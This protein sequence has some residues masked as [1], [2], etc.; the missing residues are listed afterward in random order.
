MLPQISFNEE[1]VNWWFLVFALGCLV[2]SLWFTI[3]SRNL[4]NK[5]FVIPLTNPWPA[6]RSPLSS[7]LWLIELMCGV[8]LDE[9]CKEQKIQGAQTTTQN[10]NQKQQLKFLLAFLF[11]LHRS[12]RAIPADMYCGTRNVVTLYTHHT[13]CHCKPGF[14]KRFCEQGIN[15]SLHVTPL[16]QTSQ[17]FIFNFYSEARAPEFNC[18]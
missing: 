8:L 15:L 6:I 7:P 9:R 16:Q 12:K 14:Q 13:E 11:L 5:I 4:C 3:R 2:S 1:V 17:K 10:M 18:N